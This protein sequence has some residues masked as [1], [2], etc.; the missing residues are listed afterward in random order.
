[1]VLVVL[2]FAEMVPRLITAGYEW[3]D[4]ALNRMIT[5]AYRCWPNEWA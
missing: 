3:A 1:M 2:L 4:L 5:C